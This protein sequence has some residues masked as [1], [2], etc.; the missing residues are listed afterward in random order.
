MRR[1]ILVAAS[2]LVAA[3]VYAAGGREAG[4]FDY[5]EIRALEVEAGTFAVEIHA[6]RGRRASLEIENYPDRFTVYHTVDGSTVRVWVERD[7]SLFSGPHRG[8]LVFLVPERMQI[9]VDNTTGDIF[10]EGV[11]VTELRVK[12]T[13][14]DIVVEDVV[15]DVAARSTTGSVAVRDSRGGFEVGSTTGS[16]ELH[17]VSGSVVGSSSTGSHEYRSV[18]G[19]IDARSTTGRIRLSDTEG[20][21]RLR[22]STGN[23]IGTDVMLTGDSSFEASTGSIQVDLEN[24]I[25]ELEFDLTSTTGS[26]EVGR[27][28]SQRRLFLG[29]TGIAVRGET[30]TGS[31]RYH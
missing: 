10:V 28:Q 26:L 5:D 23:Q 22:T 18:T 1:L 2:L 31:Q 20:R 9:R 29:S 19:D 4:D 17:E 30:S 25:D 15:G 13:T 7:F 6:V 27:E 14:G 3:V 11:T 16:L 8:R 12:T 24:D 21:L